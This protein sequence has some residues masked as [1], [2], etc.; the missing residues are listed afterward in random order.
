MNDLMQKRAWDN[1]G[2]LRRKSERATKK[3]AEP[4]EEG[5]SNYHSHPTVTWSR[6]ITPVRV[7]IA[8]FPFISRR[9][10]SDT[11]QTRHLAGQQDAFDE[12]FPS[13]NP[14]CLV[15][16][17]KVCQFSHSL[18]ASGLNDCRGFCLRTDLLLL[19]GCQYG[20]TVLPEEPS[21]PSCPLVTEF[22]GCRVPTV[23]NRGSYLPHSRRPR[24]AVD[25][26]NIVL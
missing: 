16:M 7:Q 10:E 25:K 23:A 18:N 6:S 17:L 19:R 2:G 22:S 21:C 26:R 14:H 9:M 3:A 12:G 24:S 13:P 4:K 1:A 5:K 15:V 11:R 8:F 20:A